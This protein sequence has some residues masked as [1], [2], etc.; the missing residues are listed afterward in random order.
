MTAP[1]PIVVVPEPEMTDAKVRAA[2]DLLDRYE[3][4]TIIRMVYAA[5]GGLH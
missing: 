3:L 4:E 1:V 2:L 5:H